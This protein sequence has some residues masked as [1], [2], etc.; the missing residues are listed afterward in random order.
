M[1]FQIDKTEPLHE[2]E[3]ETKESAAEENNSGIEEVLVNK[4]D[5]Y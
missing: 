3:K 2:N 5:K 4:Q 1:I